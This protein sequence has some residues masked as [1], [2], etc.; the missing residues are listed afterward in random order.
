MEHAHYYGD[1]RLQNRVVYSKGHDMK[2]I[3]CGESANT[4]EHVPSKVFLSRPYPENLPTV[5]ACFDCNNS[6]SED[7]LFLSL[8]MVRVIPSPKK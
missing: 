7:E 3:Y 8:F 5:P 1:Y 2:C 6:F 4:R